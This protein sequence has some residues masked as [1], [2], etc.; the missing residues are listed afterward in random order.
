MRVLLIHTCGLGG[1][2]ALADPSL[3]APV[4]AMG[5]LAPRTFSEGLMPAVR[6]M[7]AGAGWSVGSLGVVGVVDGPGS[8]TGV[9][10]GLSVGKGLCEALGIPL[11]GVSRLALLGRMVAGLGVVHAVLDAG[12]GEFYYGLVR[13]G[14][15]EAEALV[16]GEELLERVG[17]GLIG[18]CEAKAG[19]ALEAMGL[20][21]R[22]TRVEEPSA[23]AALGLVME[24]LAGGGEGVLGD[25]NYLR[26][27]DGEIFSNMKPKA[28]G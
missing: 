25:A 11:V 23:G 10:T 9:R 26:R 1:S 15:L 20:S 16:G 2:V 22:T 17:D 24:G 8:F 18:V 19:A 7:L 12:R 3:G 28:A 27:T 5:E 21:E 14:L 6:E 13:D 4:V